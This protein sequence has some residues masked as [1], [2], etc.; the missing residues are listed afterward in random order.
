MMR[1]LAFAGALAAL[2]GSALADSQGFAP[3]SL[4]TEAQLGHLLMNL[5]QAS[6][7]DGM[8]GRFDDIV[9]YVGVFEEAEDG[10]WSTVDGQVTISVSGNVLKATCAMDIAPGFVTDDAA[11]VE[12][13]AS[14]IA[15]WTGETTYTRD[16]ETEESHTW[17]WSDGRAD[18]ML[19]YGPA[20][21][22]HRIAL[23]GTM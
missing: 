15:D 22:G 21:G 2:S 12:G 3:G 7:P 8:Q 9:P 23:V 10:V 1:H 6:T 14:H 16:A 20:D 13:L 5:C 18:F 11:V 17:T 19:T 4:P